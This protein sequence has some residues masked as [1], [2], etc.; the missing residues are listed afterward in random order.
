[1]EDHQV[2]FVEYD[3]DSA[4]ESIIEAPSL[5]TREGTFQGLTGIRDTYIGYII[6]NL[7]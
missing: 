5:I 6:L 4:G 3:I 1:L 7:E 2:E